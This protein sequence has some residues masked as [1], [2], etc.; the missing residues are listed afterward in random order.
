MSKNAIVFYGDYTQKYDKVPLCGDV[1]FFFWDQPEN[2]ILKPYIR[3]LTIKQV[4][5]K[6]FNKDNVEQIIF[7]DSKNREGNSFD[8]EFLITKAFSYLKDY[9]N[10][11][12]IRMGADLESVCIGA[13]QKTSFFSKEDPY[14]FV[15][16]SEDV[17]TVLSNNKTN[18]IRRKNNYKLQ[19]KKIASHVKGANF[20]LLVNRWKEDISWLKKVAQENNFVEKIVII[21]KNNNKIDFCEEKILNIN[22]YNKGRESSC[23][24][25]FIIECYDDLPEFT[26]FAQ[27]H[28]FDHSPDLLELI[29]EKQFKGYDKKFQSLTC[30][31]DH[32]VPVKY[33]SKYGSQFINKKRVHLYTVDTKNLEIIGIVNVLDNIADLAFSIQDKLKSMDGKY[34][35]YMF[36]RI[37]LEK[38]KRY[39]HF[40]Y[41]AMFCIHK[42]AILRHEKDF[43]INLKE[44]IDEEPYSPWLLEIFWHYIFTGES[45][46]TSLVGN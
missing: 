6:F 42:E 27:A 24:I 31:Y 13:S 30:R 21:D 7:V 10:I 20:C 2:E 29:K 1:F 37:R 25:D 26:C 23:Y 9:E 5:N 33:P 38:P 40:V 16:S 8:D 14:R 34:F 32:N 36:D 22:T 39:I 28:P 3:E 45:S 35:D 41:G 43:Y 17:L 11:S 46:T 15:S 4:S 12:I 19:D 44:F 18:L